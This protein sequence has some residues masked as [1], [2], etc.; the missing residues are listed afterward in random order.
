MRSRPCVTTTGFPQAIA[1]SSVVV[2]PRVRVLAD[3]ERDDDARRAGTRGRAERDVDLESHVRRHDPERARVVGERRRG[4]TGPGAA[5]PDEPGGEVAARVGSDRD[6]VVDDRGRGVADGS[7]RRRR[8]TATNSTAGP[9]SPSHARSSSTSPT[10]RRRSCE[11]PK[12]VRE[13]PLAT[14]PRSCSR[15]SGSPI[16]AYTTGGFT[17]PNRPRSASGMP[18]V[19]TVEKTTSAR[20]SLVERGQ[21]NAREVARVAAERRTARSSS[22]PVVR[23]RRP[24]RSRPRGCADVEARASKLVEPVQAV[25][26]DGSPTGAAALPA[27]APSRGRGRRRLATRSGSVRPCRAPDEDTL[28]RA[29]QPR[30]DRPRE[31]RR[32]RDV[33]APRPRPREPL[34]PPALRRLGAAELDDVQQRIVSELDADGYCVLPFSELIPDPA[35]VDGDREAG[36]TRSSRRPKP[37]LA[38]DREALRVRAGKEFVVRLHSYGVDLGSTTPGSRRARRTACSTS[39]TPTSAC[40][41]SS[42]TSTSG[43][44]CRS[45][46][47]PTASPPSAGTATS[48]TSTS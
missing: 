41:R 27:A 6:D 48:T 22:R 33:H 47:T 20:F 9:S 19:S 25:A 35:D 17:R 39:R 32:P 15:R 43:T 18:T 12:R 26:R 2:A 42:S 40:G 11:P 28:R 7:A 14:R 30:R 45:R 13:E 37:A 24:A 29:D 21:R 16:A 10:R 3:G 31:A 46:P 34:E 44:R 1:W 5:A 8:R 23:A 36:E 4:T 38:G